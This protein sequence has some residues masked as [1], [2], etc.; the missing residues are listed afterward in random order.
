MS[1]DKQQNITTEEGCVTGSNLSQLTGNG[2]IS[3]QQQHAP[4]LQVHNISKKIIF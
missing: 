3:Q 4:P 1:S 2:D